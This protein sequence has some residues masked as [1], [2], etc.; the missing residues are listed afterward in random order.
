V[1][2]KYRWDER[3]QQ[4]AHAAGIMVLTPE[5]KMARYLYGASF[6]ARDLR[7]SLAEASENRSTMAVQKMLL[8]C[9]HYDPQ[10][11]GY[12]LFATNLMR[13]GGVLTVL[14]IGF[15]LWRMILA[16]RKKAFA[17]GPKAGRFKEGIV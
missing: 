3:T 7:F 4:F 14:L 10:A 15:F 11:G 12:V 6:H 17:N 5:G 2:F 1:G 9:Y 16:E 13:A 8:F